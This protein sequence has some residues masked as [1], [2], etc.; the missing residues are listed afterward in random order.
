MRLK[1]KLYKN[2]VMSKFTMPMRPIML[3]RAVRREIE[4]IADTLAKVS[5]IFLL[6]ELVKNN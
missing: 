5:V 4:H 2:V 3:K 6:T 1:P